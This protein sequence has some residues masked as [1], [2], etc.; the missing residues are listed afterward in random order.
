MVC[1]DNR[2]FDLH[3]LTTTDVEYLS[4]CVLAIMYVFFGKLSAQVILKSDYL[5]FSY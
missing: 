5:I 4:M 3:L 2:G 1:G